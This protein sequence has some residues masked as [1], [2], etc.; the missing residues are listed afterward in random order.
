MSI[1]SPETPSH[2]QPEQR[3]GFVAS[4]RRLGPHFARIRTRFFLGLGSAILASFIALAV[5]QVLRALVDGPLSSG[6]RSQ[7]AV[8]GAVV[9]ALGVLEAALWWGRR[10][11][12]FSPATML[13][14]DMR[15]ELY[16]KLQNLP[17]SFHDRWES[18]QL[19]SRS[20]TDL[21][22]IRRWLT[23]GSVILIVNSTMTV[24]G[25]TILI[26]MSPL[27]GLAFLAFT[28]PIV[29]IT[30]RF[31]RHYERA[32]RKSQDQTGGLATLVEQS[33]HGIRVLKAF[34]RGP[35]ALAQFSE[36]AR[37]LSNTELE[38]AREE[39]TV[40][41]WLIIIPQ[42]A[43]GASLAVGVWQASIGVL[44][45]GELVAFFTTATALIWPINT[46]GLLFAETVNAK[47]ALDR[48]FEVTDTAN[49]VTSP[50]APVSPATHGGELVFEDVHFRYSDARDS[51]RDLLDGVTLRIRAGESLALV[52]V[53]GSGK[54]AMTELVPRLYD[55]T[56]GRILLDGV[57]VRA[58]SLPEL[59]QRVA[60]A[61]EEPTLFS[62]TVRDNVLLGNPEAGDAA[63]QA[64]LAIAQADFVNELPD[65]VDTVIGEEGHSLSG[66]QRQRLALAR[67]VAA[68]PDVL[69]LDDP[70][71]A[72]DVNTEAK[73]ERALHDVLRTTTALIVA[74]RPST[75]AMADRVALLKDG[76]IAAVGTHSELLATSEDY[77][78]VISSL[79]GADAEVGVEASAGAGSDGEVGR[80]AA[81]ASTDTFSSELPG[82][83]TE[84]GAR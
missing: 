55:V 49:D 68:A 24:A 67:A 25:I 20:S 69:V 47:T 6:D 29:P 38:K 74:H 34:G 13:E 37:E 61:F 19:L 35:E 11:F 31:E 28:L 82:T 44:S 65:G 16:D 30:F 7:V 71:S 9:L 79:D 62:E 42:V 81:A 77:R 32:S 80:F 8:A 22:A 43:I 83:V 57:D 63:L 5:P 56:G 27:L 78:F 18:G 66:G 1:P 50:T 36:R 53:T 15:R 4:L 72:L 52:G 2:T 40:W 26:V 12:I 21:S 39:S 48:V 33:V 58:I 54:S 46:L 41:M 59:R 3:K 45:L 73:V 51:E 84:G 64:A 17:V 60:V 75:V 14:Y 10:A 76:K 23:F 70:L